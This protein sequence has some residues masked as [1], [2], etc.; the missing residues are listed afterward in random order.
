V[1]VT[2]VNS[3]YPGSYLSAAPTCSKASSTL[4]FTTYARANLAVVGLSG[5]VFCIA[6]NTSPTDVIVD[7]LG[8]MSPTGASFVAMPSPVRI[9]DTRTGNGGTGNGG[10]PK[11]VG[12]GRSI[13]VVGA[14]LGD[15][16]RAATALFT[17]VVDA[18]ATSTGYLTAFQGATKPAGAASTLDFTA[19]RIVPNAAIIGVSGSPPMFG[20][21]NSYGSTNIAVDLFGYFI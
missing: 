12:A 18:S 16:P 8:Y 15:V 3:A 20:V 10:T 14:G 4:N 21:F 5:G 2:V 19:G 6:N 1:N 7:V 9:V 13:T 17:S 11:A